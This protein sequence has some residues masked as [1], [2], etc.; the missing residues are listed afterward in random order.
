M[1][2]KVKT[3][4][5]QQQK[6]HLGRIILLLLVFATF[7]LIFAPKMGIYS[8]YRENDKLRHL[9]EERARLEQENLELRHEIERIQ[10]DIEYFEKLAREKHNLLKKNEI[11]FDFSKGDKQSK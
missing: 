3:S 1:K 11:L 9:V 7:W 8:L 4:L 10:Q 6:K 2:R 5:T